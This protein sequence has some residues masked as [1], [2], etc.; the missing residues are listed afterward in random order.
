LDQII[1]YFD[2]TALFPNMKQIIIAG[3]SLGA[4]TVQRYAAIGQPGNTHSPVSYWVA[5]PNSY[6]W[7]SYSRPLFTAGCPIYDVYREG[8]T[9]FT[10]Y[11]MTYGVALVNSGRTNILATYNSKAINYGRG[12]QD[13]GDDSSNCAPF[14]TGANRN[15]RFFNFIAA[16]PP[17]C[18]DPAGR[19]CDTVDFVNVGHDAGQMMASPAGQARLF[20][21]NFHGNG[22]RAYDFGYPRQQAGDDPYPDPALNGT[23]ASVNNNTYAGNMTYWG[24]WSDQTPRSLANL[25]YTSN[26]NTIELCTSTCAQ[27][28]NTI[29]GMEYG[30]QCFCGSALGYQAT[31]IVDSS[32]SMACPGN[33][34]E[35]CG[36]I[37]RLSL[38]SNG[39]PVIQAAPG[40]PETVGDF[41]YAACY[42][43]AT[44]G[45]AL[46][47]K[48]TSG[49]SMTLEYCANFCSGFQ[50]FGTEYSDE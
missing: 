28:N 1:Q 34:S 31:E 3:H 46:G 10:Q 4:Q 36:G 13:L 18:A 50:Y 38:F 24:C 15:E 23:A 44:S 45:R 26:A 8:Y 21:D 12:T 25:S 32:C 16:F 42:T 39:R 29:A 22:S 40:T 49:F 11:P 47:G 9:N 41:Y 5:N 17:T 43:E 14:T 30:S 20:L 27:G 48:S 33:S 35:T 37:N 2:N 7:F 19:N 6:A